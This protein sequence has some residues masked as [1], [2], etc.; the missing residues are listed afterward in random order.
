[1]LSLR[2]YRLDSAFETVVRT[3]KLRKPQRESLNQVHSLLKSMD[4]DLPDLSTQDIVLKLREAGIETGTE[5][6]EILFELATGV[7]KTRLMGAL[8][9]YLFR[10]GQ[11]RNFLILA[12]RKAIL[13]KLERESDT[14]SSKYLFIDPALVP[15]PNLCFRS[16][17]D[18]FQ[19]DPRRP[20]VF[21]LSPQTIT[22]SDRRFAKGN[23]FSESVLKYLTTTTDLIV[24]TDEA[25][26]IGVSSDESPAWRQSIAALRPR[27]HFGFTATVPAGSKK[28]VLYS[29]PLQECLRDGLYT[30]SVKLWVEPEPPEVS[31]EE[32][33]HITLDFALQRLES[34]RAGLR[35]YCERHPEVEFIE[36]VLLVAARDT[37]HANAT[38]TW[39]NERRGLPQEAFH[40]AHSHRT[41][42]EEEVEKLVAIDRPGNKIRV[43]INVFQLSEGWDVTNVY[44]VAPLR[45]MATFENAVQTMGR[46]LRLPFG[47]RTGELEVDNLDVLCF[48]KSTFEEIVEKATKQF[49]DE[50]DGMLPVSLGRKQDDIE[51]PS[52]TKPILISLRKNVSF[53]MPRVRRVPPEP[54]LQF[55]IAPSRE[56]TRYVAGLDLIS[57]DRSSGSEDTLRYDVQSVIR[58]AALRVLSELQYL[59]APSHMAGVTA[60]IRQLLEEMGATDGIEVA[61]DPLKVATLVIEEIDKRY[62]LQPAKFVLDGRVDIIEPKSFEWRLRNDLEGPIDRG[63][64]QRL[65]WQ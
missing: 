22:G 38:A 21:I 57:L 59:S 33:D 46:G 8:I 64:G 44:V 56:L 11:S 1:M 20:N 2:T 30:K 54:D 7:G 36:P 5:V 51:F 48:G 53:E 41:P 52:E 49:G 4:D 63:E 40:V 10:A 27:L 3:S 50:G 16:T 61:V 31:D 17:L 60:L 24:C 28:R 19:P 45:A 65:K 13:E 47:R 15:E 23:D 34:K 37:D 62:K 6:P 26:H 43:V 39:L 29:Y 58:M 14:T 55:T 42:S 25:H 32:W 35:D 9:A 18:S 12:P